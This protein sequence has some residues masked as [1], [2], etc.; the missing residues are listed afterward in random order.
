MTTD[1]VQARNEFVQR[2]IGPFDSLWRLEGDA[3]T[4]EYFRVLKGDSAYILCHDSAFEGK[5][6]ESYPFMTVHGLLQKQKIPV[7][8]ILFADPAAGLLIEEDCGDVLL[9]EYNA[10]ASHDARMGQYTGLLEILVRMQSIPS[11]GSIPFTLT[12]DV[13]KLMFEFNFFIEH[14]LEGHFRCTGSAVKQELHDEFLRISMELYQPEYFV[15]THRDYHSRNVL[16]HKGRPVIIDFQDARLGLPQYDLVSLLRDSYYTLASEDLNLLK[17]RYYRHSKESGVHSMSPDEFD[18]YFDLMAFQRNIKAL[19]T[20]A[21]QVR[22]F[23][24]E[25][26]RKYISPTLSYLE[27]YGAR[28]TMLKRSCALLNDAIGDLR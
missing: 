12:F 14:A 28:H 19:G 23:G 5:T 25:K 13:E 4:R 18:Y 22:H 2:S 21:Y 10:T 20:F 24:R 3:S 6:V 16:V 17:Q 15:F 9:E 1:P 26:F 7:P 8:E 11:D 27:D